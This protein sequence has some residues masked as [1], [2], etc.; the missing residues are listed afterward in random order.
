ML[1]HWLSPVN[2]GQIVEA[3]LQPWQLGARVRLHTESGLPGL[4]GV[5]IALIGVGTA[6]ADAARK[7][8]YPMAF[9]F[10][11]LKI[12]DLGNIRNNNLSFIIP[13][14]VELLHSKIVPVLLGND[15]YFG[16]S[17]F[18]A[19]RQVLENINLVVVDEK[20]RFHPGKQK[21]SSSVLHE[22]LDDPEHPLFHLGVIGFQGHFTAPDALREMERRCFDLVRLGYARANLAETEP[23]IR[24]ADLLWFHTAALKQSEAPAQATPSPSGFAIE[25]AC[26]LCRYAGMSDKLKA[27]GLFGFRA[28]YDQRQLGAQATAQMIWYFL[29][30]FHGRRNDFPAS[31]DGLVEYIVELKPHDYTLTFWKSQKT[32]RWWIQVPVETSH[33]NQRHRLIPCSYNDYKSACQDELPERLI[34]ALKRFG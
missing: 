6:D 3:E 14:L 16:L 8:L 23:V 24:D 25:E 13:T 12:A 31:L 28:E 27:F 2:P 19:A 26:Q 34:Q 18:K 10:E 9:P 11:G 29:D 30:G 1:E 5:R 17:L 4:R 21:D 20:I 15:L 7:A 32:G 33:K 22:V